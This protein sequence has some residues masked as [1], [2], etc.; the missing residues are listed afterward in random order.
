[1]D[2]RSEHPN[3][4]PPPHPAERPEEYDRWIDMYAGDEFG[5]AVRLYRALA[6][7]AAAAARYIK[8]IR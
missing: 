2:I 8:R 7:D 5:E 1:M 4:V 6:E 3:T